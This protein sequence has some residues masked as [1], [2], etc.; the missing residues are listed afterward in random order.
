MLSFGCILVVVLQK[1]VRFVA[2]AELA[3]VV[4]KEVERVHM[5]R[6]G[7]NMKALIV[8]GALTA[9]S[10]AALGQGVII[11][12]ILGST[13]SFDWEFIELLNNS[14]VSVDITG[15]AVALYES[16]AGA[17]FGGFDGSS[18]HAITGTVVL[19]P[20]QTYT[21]GGALAQTGF[22][23]GTYLGAP[24]NFDQL[25]PPNAIENS[26]YTAVL[27][28]AAGLNMFSVFATD[29]GVGD[30]PNQ[31][32]VAIVPDYSFGPDGTFVPAGAAV[33]NKNFDTIQLSFSTS[34][35]AGGNIAGGTPGV[36][37]KNIPAPGA[38][39][40]AGVAGLAATRRRR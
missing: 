10:G 33:L 4:G 31:A 25:L 35:L 9:M 28:N 27:E 12:E 30:G 23:G 19:A 40:L 8:A 39:M 21:M 29:G 37:Q 2:Q 36:D 3:N 11:N 20:G 34:G 24:F 38:L 6:E 18:P 15:W 32:G 22:A 26:S 17:S 13:S 16:D 1:S 5:R 14:A 7:K